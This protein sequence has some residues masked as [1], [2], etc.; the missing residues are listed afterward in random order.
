MSMPEFVENFVEADGFRIRY[1]EAGSGQ[2]L[3]GLH[4]AGG[5][6]V[7]R[8]HEL[9][10]EKCRVIVFEAP[11]FGSSPA[12]ERTKTMQ[13]LADTIAAAAIAIGLDRY[14]LMGNSFGGRLALWTAIRHPRAIG[15]LILVAP[16]AV[17]LETTPTVR[18]A[19]RLGLLYA[20]PERQPPM[21]P[22][23]PEVLAKQEALL[24]RL[25][26]PPRDA[27][28]ESQMATLTM[29]SLVMFGTLDK[30]FPPEVGRVYR[31]K[32]PNCNLV[33]VY[34]AG[35]ALD[36]DRPEAFSALVGDFLERREGFLVPKES[37]LLHP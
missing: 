24:K 36:A 37:R 1:K 30:M 15:S 9:L 17:K 3:V 8:S 33:F 26:G 29:P 32:M 4:G 19:D 28:L 27:D 14:N 35:H 12:N 25:A 7:S 13:D 5:L 10:A 31:E 22:P 23:S 18:P 34:D 21:T 16:A 2:P 20:H 11:G 6:R